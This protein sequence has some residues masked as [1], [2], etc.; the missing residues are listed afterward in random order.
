MVR[1]YKRKTDRASYT[2]EQINLAFKTIKLG[3]SIR[4]AALENGIVPRTL[5]NY[6]KK[7]NLTS[8]RQNNAAELADA[9]PVENDIAQTRPESV[10]LSDLPISPPLHL[11]WLLLLH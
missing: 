2:M 6:W 9:T 10:G 8:V 3:S 1:N 5:E 4:R 11:F 7:H